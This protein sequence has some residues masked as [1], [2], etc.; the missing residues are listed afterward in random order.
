[1]RDGVIPPTTGVTEVS[2]RYRLD[3]VLERPRAAGL[4][5]ALVLARGRGGHNSAVVL[6][7]EPR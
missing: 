1:M 7:D 4:R 2:E 6:A 3:L 5:T